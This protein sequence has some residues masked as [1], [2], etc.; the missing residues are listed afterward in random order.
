[1]LSLYQQQGGMFHCNIADGGVYIVNEY[2]ISQ[3]TYFRN[4][5][6]IIIIAKR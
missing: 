4:H 3:L 6:A 1:M 2:Q 5:D